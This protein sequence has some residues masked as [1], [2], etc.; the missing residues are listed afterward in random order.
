M[1]QSRR[2]DALHILLALLRT[3]GTGAQAMLGFAGVGMACQ[4][5]WPAYDESKTVDST[6]TMAVQVGGKLRG[7]V[8][9]PVDSEQDVVLE[10]ALADAKVQ[11]FTDGMEIFKVILVKNKL[12]NLI[13][14]PKK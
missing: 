7:T 10:A 2:I 13:V 3:E 14:R 1:F 6:V 4:Q 8:E 9:V 12:I 5:S 11:K